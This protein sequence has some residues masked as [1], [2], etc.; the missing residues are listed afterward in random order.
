MQ[1]TLKYFS[2]NVTSKDD[3]SEKIFVSSRFDGDT[4]VHIDILW[5]G[6]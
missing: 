4:S 1:I 6:K 3:S 2:Y 5:L